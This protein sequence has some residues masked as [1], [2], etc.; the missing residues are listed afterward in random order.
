M[1]SVYA[2][3]IPRYKI[4]L[5]IE[6]MTHRGAPNV[7]FWISDKNWFGP[8]VADT[9]YVWHAKYLGVLIHFSLTAIVFEISDIPY[10]D[11]SRFTT[12]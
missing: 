9:L 3:Q 1:C 12:L 2:D 5:K 10:P 6:A 7:L 8:V 11:T 4:S